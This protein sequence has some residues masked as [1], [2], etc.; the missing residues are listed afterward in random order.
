MKNSSPLF[1]AKARQEGWVSIMA[2]GGSNQPCKAHLAKGLHPNTG[3]YVF[4]HTFHGKRHSY[5]PF[6][7]QLS[8]IMEENMPNTQPSLPTSKAAG[9]RRQQERFGHVNQPAQAE[10]AAPAW[11]TQPR[12]PTRKL[13]R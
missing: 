5:P 2:G 6:T 10:P 9:G 8:G 12:A 4:E 3:S 13:L 1:C 11:A 7:A